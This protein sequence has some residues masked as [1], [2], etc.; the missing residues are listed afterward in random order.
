MRVETGCGS[1][2]CPESEPYELSTACEM[3]FVRLFLER[4]GELGGAETEGEKSQTN[5][6]LSS[7]PE[8]GLISGP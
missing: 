8:V 5:S 3:I 4:K 2:G 7:E 6:L 1:E